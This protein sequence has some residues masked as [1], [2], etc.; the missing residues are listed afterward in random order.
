MKILNIHFKNINSLEGEHRVDFEQAPFTD[1]GVFA[2]TGP[3]GAGKSSLLDVITL[4]LYGETFRFDR[5]AQHVLTRHTDAGFAVIEFSVGGSQYQSSWHVQRE[6]GQFLPP[7]M[8]LK[9][10]PDATLLADSP[11]QV[12]AKTTDI[13]GM[14]FRNFTRSILLAQGDFAAFLSALDSERMDILEKIISTDIYADYKRDIATKADQ[15]QQELQRLQHELAGITLLPPETQEA[16]AHDLIDFNEHWAELKDEHAELQQQQALLMDANALKRQAN[17]QEQL[18]SLTQTQLEQIQQ[19]LGQIHA[20]PDVLSFKDDLERQH[21]KTHQLHQ[22]KAQLEAMRQELQQLQQQLGDHASTAVTSKL[23]F[24]EQQQQLAELQQQ[25]QQ[26]SAASQSESLYV[27]NLAEQISSQQTALSELSGWLD[28]HTADAVL[29]TDFPEIGPLKKLRADLAECLGKHK[30]FTKQSQKTTTTANNNSSALNAEIQQHKTYQDKLA[31][32][33]AALEEMAK[34]YSVDDLDGLKLEQQERVKDFQSLYKIALRYQ[35]LT[36]NKRFF[37]L[38]KTQEPADYDADELSAELEK[39]RLEIK[40]EENIKRVLEEAIVREGLMKK[41]AAD[42]VHLVDGRP[43]PLCGALQHPYVKYPPALTNSKQAL[44]DQKAKLR[45]LLEKAATTGRKITEAGTQ[46]EKRQAKQ[47][48][49]QKLRGD[50]LTLCN[51]LNAVSEIPD[52]TQLS[53]MKQRL[54]QETAATGELA[55]FVARYRSKQQ[56]IAK[57]NALISKSLAKQAQL[58]SQT[59]QLGVNVLGLSAEQ[60]ALQDALTQCQQQEQALATTVLEQLTR[61]G[62]KMPAKGQ[63]DALIDRLNARRQEYHGYAFKHK[64]LSEELAALTAKHTAS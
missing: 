3:N 19:Q 6:N 34:G 20:S 21:D 9:L 33:Q 63:E 14:N 41:M 16:Y 57:L 48:L 24:A 56:G 54:S 39:I 29:L 62:E 45:L 2:I 53:A 1:T 64:N 59:E 5:P 46:A 44:I 7:V 60:Q 30:A 31:A 18:L 50:W 10:M 12:C 36:E 42:K 61:L 51:R 40:R 49:L 8:Q 58:Q 38:F 43:C 37:G 28:A 11:A 55:N 22:S 25:S 17:E 52:I 27:L 47:Q 32:Y 23:S 35:Q 13:T 15:A 4:G 26:L